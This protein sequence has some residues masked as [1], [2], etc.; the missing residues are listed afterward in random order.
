MSNKP[1]ALLTAE[2]VVSAAVSLAGAAAVAGGLRGSLA[3]TVLVVGGLVLV[4]VVVVLL[5]LLLLLLG[6][7]VKLLLLLASAAAGAIAV[8]VEDVAA[9]VGALSAGGVPLELVLPHKLLH[10][11][12]AEVLAVVAGLAD[13]GAVA[14]DVALV[15][16]HTGAAEVL[17]AGHIDERCGGRKVF[18]SR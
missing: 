1:H 10:R 16:G 6:G 18:G 17:M 3:L 5:L 14:N 8:R 11:V 4:G 7:I 2:D 13:A 12:A 15:L 9:L